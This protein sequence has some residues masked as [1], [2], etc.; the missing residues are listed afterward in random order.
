MITLDSIKSILYGLAIG[1]SLGVPVEFV[2][3]QD[4]IKNPIKNLK[5]FGSH[6]QPSGTW[7]DDSSMSFCLAESLCDGY[8]INDI[9]N[10]FVKWYYTGYWSARGDVFDIGINTANVLRKLKNGSNPLVSG[11]S[12]I[13]SN[14]N[15][16]LMRILPLLFYIYNKPYEERFKITKEVSS[17]T[18]AHPISIW[19]CFYYLEFAR[20]ILEGNTLQQSYDI[21]LKDKNKYGT[22]FK[23]LF[24]LDEKNIESDGYVVNT[25]TASIYCLLTTTS[26]KEA[27]LKAVNL[28]EDSD[29][30]GCV[31][32][33][34]AGLYYGFNSI[35]KH[36]I[37][38]IAKSKEIGSLAEKVF[39]KII[40]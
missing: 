9:A 8:D 7:S 34:L 40:A 2:S 24:E 26:Y 29:T 33:G 28:G 4:L 16:S 5:G 32:G 18:H 39:K 1:D 14:G 19:S 15:G 13:K 3:R 35:P 21:L 6:N 12:D 37:Q 30:T 22:Y 20:L 36:W 17:I 31:T 38:K 10:K 25:L 27:V 23:P 11:N